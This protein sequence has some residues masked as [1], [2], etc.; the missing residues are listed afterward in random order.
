MPSALVAVTERF[1]TVVTAAVYL[2]RRV[3]AQ[4]RPPR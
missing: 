1:V 3:L 2:G 4:S